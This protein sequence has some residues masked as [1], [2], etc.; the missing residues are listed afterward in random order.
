MNITDLLKSKIQ[1]LEKNIEILPDKIDVAD[2]KTDNVKNKVLKYI[3]AR[4][5]DA[6]V[7]K[8]E[9]PNKNKVKDIIK[10]FETYFVKKKT[11][12][13]FIGDNG[14]GKTL[15]A[16]LIFKKAWEINYKCTYYKSI[17]IIQDILKGNE[18][19]V[20]YCY[21][22]NMLIIDEF[23]KRISKNQGGWEVNTLFDIVDY[24]YNNFLP[25]ILI[26]NG[27]IE[28]V[29]DMSPSLADRL[30]EYEIIKFYYKSF[31]GFKK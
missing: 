7:N 13:L 21:T 8:Y 22:A 29:Y 15:A 10:N 9:G 28:D 14:T 30:T 2:N 16:S 6:D 25:T 26:A 5:V 17:S 11:N 19:E 23:D 3:G 24:R 1:D 31:R 20:S 18:K 12:F 4:Y 27:K